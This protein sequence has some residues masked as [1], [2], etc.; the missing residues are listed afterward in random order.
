MA[1]IRLAI[2]NDYEIVVRGLAALIESDDRFAV[3]DIAVDD[4][5][6]TH[7]DIALYDTFGAADPDFASARRLLD[8][9]S[10]S[11]VAVFTWSFDE[12]HIERATKAGVAGF[13]SKSLTS[14]ELAD[15]LCRIHDGEFVASSAPDPRS[16][17]ATVRRWPGQAMHLTEKEA[18]VLALI[19]QGHDNRSIA[20]LLYISPN[21][22]KTRIRGL[23]RKL[24]VDNRV[25]AALWGVENGFLPEESGG[26]ERV[27]TRD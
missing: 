4:S 12:T 26:Q 6:E 22:L 20:E 5:V 13:L 23:Y 3:V 21:T 16:D 27:L 8:G 19:T 24:G 2:V 17:R 14:R 25:Q 15:A 1:P 18:D 11:R 7:A 9:G 10:V